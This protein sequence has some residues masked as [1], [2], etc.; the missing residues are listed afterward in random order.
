M[1]LAAAE[2]LHAHAASIE[3]RTKEPGGRSQEEGV[4]GKGERGRGK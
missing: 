4:R 2:G 1:T 3:V